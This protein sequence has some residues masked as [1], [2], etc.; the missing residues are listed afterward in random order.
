MGGQT[1]GRIGAGLCI[2]L[3]VGKDD[4]QENAAAL[5]DKV[6]NLR[7]FEDDLGKMNRSVMDMR[8]RNPGGI[9]V[10][11]VRRLPAKAIDP[12]SPTPR[13]RHWRR[14]STKNSPIVCALPA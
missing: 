12:R 14:N 10:H 6:K 9:A 7:I 8:R 4:N 2:L 5:A 11:L 3:G 13:Q 1:V